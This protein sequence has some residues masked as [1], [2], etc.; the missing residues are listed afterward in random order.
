[1]LVHPKAGYAWASTAVVLTDIDA[2]FETV[3]LVE[4]GNTF[5]EGMA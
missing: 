3:G 5:T 2:N 4:D 1:M